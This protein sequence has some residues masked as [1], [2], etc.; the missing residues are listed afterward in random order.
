LVLLPVD[1]IQISPDT[2]EIGLHHA[3][4]SGP[5]GQ[6]IILPSAP[7]KYSHFPFHIFFINVLTGNQED[8]PAMVFRQYDAS[9][10]IATVFMSLQNHSQSFIQDSLGVT[11]SR[12]SFS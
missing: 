6:P 1:T 10:K 4:Q 12:K 7:Q 8:L 3:H 2:S 9:I 5:Q 11:V